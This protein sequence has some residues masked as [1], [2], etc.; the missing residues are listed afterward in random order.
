[1]LEGERTKT[2]R[3]S[4]WIALLGNALLASLKISIGIFSG[5]LA[6]LSDGIDSASDIVTSFITLFTSKIISR[7]PSKEYPYGYRRADTLA[8]KAL[9]FF[10]FFAGAQLA[11]SSAN[12]L[13]S[14]AER[15]LPA[16]IAIYVTIFSILAKLFL[17][18]YLKK[19]GKKTN[20]SM[21]I[22]NG[23][24]MRNDVI[25]SLSVLVGLIFT[26]VL[27]ISILDSVTALLVSFWIMK[28]AFDIFMES[29]V[30]LMD[31]IKD[32]AIYAKLFEIVE[33]TKGACNPHRARIRKIGNL[34]VINVDIEVDADI[35]V[36]SGHQIAER[37]E[38]NI[39]NN[40][41]N[42]YDTVVHIEP[43]GNKENNERY[44]LSEQDVK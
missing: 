13:F 36:A 33:N 21:L 32:P 4:S 30:E 29:Y 9:S 20:S 27:K 1:M 8:T 26:F 35:S 3:K 17:S 42:I 34:Y 23:K 10:I 15:D 16:K 43:K 18:W 41:D 28:V 25:I 19:Q 44:G 39:K 40:M 5:S 37:L 24:N 14:G 11:I 12:N 2:I 38:N 22:A 31:G 7:P 6:V